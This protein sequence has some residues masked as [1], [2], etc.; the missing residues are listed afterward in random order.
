MQ[1][2]QIV[3]FIYSYFIGF[4]VSGVTK[5]TNKFYTLKYFLMQVTTASNNRF[6]DRLSKYGS[7]RSK[8]EFLVHLKKREKQRGFIKL[9]YL[10]NY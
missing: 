4:S 8:I 3:E 9:N 2:F 10:R 7:D 1:V 5:G 6:L